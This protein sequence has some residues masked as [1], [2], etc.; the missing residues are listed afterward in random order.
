MR[1]KPWSIFFCVL[2]FC[3]ILCE[4]AD[5]YVGDPFNCKILC[6]RRSCRNEAED[7][8]RI[9]IVAFQRDEIETLSDW[10]QYHSYLFGI[11]NIVVIDH[12]STNQNIIELL[13]LYK[14][15]GATIVQL[16]KH[17]PFDQKYMM[18]TKELKQFSNSL[19]VPL[20]VDEFVVATRQV[21]TEIK[22]I[23]ER[24][25]I[26][27]RFASLPIDGRK[28]KFQQ[29]Y[30]MIGSNFSCRSKLESGEWQDQQYRRT[31][32]AG[33]MAWENVTDIAVKM[34]LKTFFYSEG[35]LSTDAG[36]HHGEVMHDYGNI[37]G[38]TVRQNTARFYIF[39]NLSLLHYSTPSFYGARL[40]FIRGAV[41]YG[42]LHGSNCTR[43]GI[44]PG[45]HYCS[46]APLFVNSTSEIARNAYMTLCSRIEWPYHQKSEESKHWFERN[47]IPL[48]DLF[49]KTGRNFVSRPIS[50]ENDHLFEVFQ[51]NTSK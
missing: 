3:L 8:L 14:Q 6:A 35:F 5:N 44:M 51:N 13:G 21:D 37:V 23:Q 1:F 20:D 38:P 29:S 43:P 46:G 41:A 11:K 12:A 7:Q 31:Q 33:Y 45:R 24:A 10:L 16:P 4:A 18:M 30:N 27:K 47:A 22:I 49:H 15:C 25:E 26:I 28:Y 42:H 36:N 17:F 40:K 19:L 39:S 34:K 50:Y 9:K 48:K 2:L 32:R